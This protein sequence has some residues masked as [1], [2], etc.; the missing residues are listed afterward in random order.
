M[1]RSIAKCITNV[2]ETV[3]LPL[4]KRQRRKT[5][6]KIAEN[7]IS[8][9]HRD[10]KTIFG[11]FKIMAGYSPNIASAAE[12]F[13][14]DEPETLDYIQKYVGAGDVFWDIGANIGLISLCAAAKN[15]TVYAFEPSGFNF[16]ILVQ[17]IFL[18]GAGDKI[19]PFSI[20][21]SDSNKIETLHMAEVCGGHASNS[22]GQAR[23]QTTQFK[24]EFAQDVLVMTGDYFAQTY[25]CYP[26]HIKLDVDGIE[27]IIL[28]GMPT[29]LNQVETLIVEIEGDNLNKKA[30]MLALIE[31]AGLVQESTDNADG[32]NRN[33]LFVRQNK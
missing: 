1:S 16:G 9:G 23:N 32:E 13:Q 18:N 14:K 31:K 7:L 19:K 20:A 11:D 15:A 29:I 30:D 8:N 6:A 33:Y 2:V 4:S 21:L 28:Q 24:S 3:T 12:T 22:L 10:V 17:H 26:K 25:N 27:P 5:R